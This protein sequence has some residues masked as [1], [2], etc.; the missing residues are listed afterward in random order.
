MTQL[1]ERRPSLTPNPDPV[2]ADGMHYWQYRDEL[3]ERDEIRAGSAFGSTIVDRSE[4]SPILG[5]APHWSHR[6]RDDLEPKMVIDPAIRLVDEDPYTE[7]FLGR[8]PHVILPTQSRYEVDM[9]RPPDVAIYDTPEMA[10]GETVYG[11]DLDLHDRETTMEKWYEFHG[12]LDAAIQDAIERFGIAVLFDV[13]SYNYQR[14]ER[15]DW[16]DH[17][18][19]VINLG[20]SHL[21]LDEQGEKIKEAAIDRLEDFTVDGE[22]VSFGESEVFYGGY[23]NRRLSRFY[24]PRVVT[25]S[26][27]F[28][29]IFMDER[30]GEPHDDVLDEL[31]DRFDDL[32]DD[33]AGMLDAP[34]RDPPE[35]P[36]EAERP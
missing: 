10:W 2:E 11:E 28:Q 25:L 31:V 35:V 8:V 1:D 32:V 24:G 19:P 4:P 20:T 15:V 3:A 13:H 21:R 5:T 18:D 12:F 9:N 29:K 16:R 34:V 27:E 33:L 30:T 36:V 6:I 7:R 14:E 17:E 23:I 26:V 22:T